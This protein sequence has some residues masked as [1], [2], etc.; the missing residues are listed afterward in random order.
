MKKVFIYST[1][2]A[3]ACLCGAEEL[4]TIFLPGQPW[5]DDHDIHI[6]AHGGGV[7]YNEGTYY[8]FGEHKIAGKAGNE[9]HVGVHCYSSTNLY[10]WK[11]EGVA[12]A[13]SQDPASDI[14]SGCLLER[15]KV[16][17][18]PRTGKYV[19]WFHLELKGKGYDAA[20]SGVAV[21]EVITGPYTYLRSFRPNAGSWPV[22][23]TQPRSDAANTTNY[24]ARDFA[25]GQMARDMTL[26][27][28]DDAMAYQIYASEENETLQISQLSDDYLS[29]TGKYV[30]V[31]EK[32]FNEAPAI[33]KYQG[34]YWML[35][36]GCSGWDPNTARASI[37]DSIWGPWKQ[38]GNPCVGT[39][40]QNQLSAGLTFGGQST[41]IFPVAGKPG[42]F[43][44]MFDVWEPDDAIRGG[45]VWLPMVF[46]KDHFI[47]A[48]RN[49]WDLSV[50]EDV[51]PAS[52][53]STRPAGNAQT[54]SKKSSNLLSD[55]QAAATPF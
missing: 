6:N 5:P 51:K 19:M 24:L 38:I 44:A 26:F 55:T 32:Q 29:P 23:Q 28:D 3:M 41:C 21:A 48:W 50:F 14:A 30:R 4:R 42:A 34:H 35:T 45:Y 12:L 53:Q 1:L 49:A 33:C 27:V 20:R 15:P 18:N 16:I 22:G 40:S 43:I 52:N 9:A 7:I 13:V 31:F 2:V 10:N 36:S 39:N 25:G 11:D 8:W 37:A 17:H 46:E 54:D 47:I